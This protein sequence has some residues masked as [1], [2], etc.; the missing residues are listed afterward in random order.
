MELSQ[1]P[2]I[3]QIKNQVAGMHYPGGRVS[4]WLF[5]LQVMTPLLNHCFFTEGY[6][7]HCYILSTCLVQFASC[8]D[9]QYIMNQNDLVVPQTLVEYF[10][11]SV[12]VTSPKLAQFSGLTCV[13]GKEAQ[14]YL[15]EE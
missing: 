5:N 1:S 10:E 13:F 15:D 6:T 4:N 3:T 11:T 2:S 12:R 8:A 14:Q 7:I 9:Q